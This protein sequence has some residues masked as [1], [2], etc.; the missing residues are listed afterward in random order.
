VP[1]IALDDPGGGTDA[2]GEQVGDAGA[3][4]G[5]AGGAGAWGGQVE[6]A[7]A[8]DVLAGGAGAWGEKGI[9][10][11]QPVGMLHLGT[12]KQKTLVCA[13]GR[14]AASQ[15][16]RQYGEERLSATQT[17]LARGEGPNFG[18]QKI[19]EYGKGSDFGSQRT[20]ECGQAVCCLLHS[21]LPSWTTRQYAEGS[22]AAG[23][24]KIPPLTRT[25]RYRL[26]LRVPFCFQGN[27]P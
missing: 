10:H 13:V 3:W 6:G 7:G 2:W 8:W 27:S 20:Q 18:R 9:A 14:L 25:W 1:V 12:A 16:T 15:T 17:T 5:Q 19:R 22:P 24:S 11:F 21:Y 26:R 4:G 23:F